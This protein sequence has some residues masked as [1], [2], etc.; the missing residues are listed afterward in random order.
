MIF[1]IRRS[2]LVAENCHIKQLSENPVSYYPGGSVVGIDRWR[3]AST[4]SVIDLKR[5][6]PSKDEF[7]YSRIRTFEPF[8]VQLRQISTESFISGKNGVLKASL[9]HWKWI[10]L[11]KCPKE[12]IFHFTTTLINIWRYLMGL[13]YLFVTFRSAVSSQTQSNSRIFGPK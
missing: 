2:F 9:A 4:R 5:A 1:S 3:F 13:A 7:K 12:A 11:M 8:W 6:V 10:L